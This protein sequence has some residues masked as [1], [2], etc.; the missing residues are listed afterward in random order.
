MLNTFP[1]ASVNLDILGNAHHRES[2]AVLHIHCGACGP[3]CSVAP[4]MKA[5]IS[6]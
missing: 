4:G 3:L 5:S 6:S 1:Q 2:I